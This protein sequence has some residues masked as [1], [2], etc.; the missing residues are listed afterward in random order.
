M[1]DL[2]GVEGVTARY[3][4][5]TALSKASLA[6]PEATMVGVVGVNGAGK[7]TL[8]RVIA[9][10]L[11]PARGRVTYRGRDI[12][13]TRVDWRARNGIAFLPESRELF[14]SMSVLDNLCLGAVAAGKRPK[15]HALTDELEVVFSYFPRLRERAK[16]PA[17]SM[18]GGEQQMLAIGRLLMGKPR[19]VLLDEPSLGLSPLLVKEM[20]HIIRRMRDELNLTVVVAEQNTNMILKNANTVYALSRGETRFLGRVEQ[21]SEALTQADL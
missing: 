18:S 13:P 4:L 1:D 11:A 5:S 16:Q 12:T 8:L 15:R 10:L 3:E 20:F 17:S 21:A 14:G 6:V 7:T 2:L 9:G 19:L